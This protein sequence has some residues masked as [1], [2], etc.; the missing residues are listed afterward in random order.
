MKNAFE[1]VFQTIWCR[2][3]R[4]MTAKHGPL[5]STFSAVS[6]THVHRDSNSVASE[7]NPPILQN[8]GMV[9]AQGLATFSE[10]VLFGKSVAPL[11]HRREMRPS[12]S[13]HE[14]LGIAHLYTTELSVQRKWAWRMQTR[15]AFP[16]QRICKLSSAQHRFCGNAADEKVQD[17]VKKQTTRR[18]L[19]RPT[20]LRW[21][22]RG[23]NTNSG[24]FEYKNY[25]IIDDLQFIQESENDTPSSKN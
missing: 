6:R 4:Y 21:C 17:L 2:K 15:E 9:K 8:L 5:L 11:S 3:K 20:I 23:W 7:A 25:S 18:H 19:L 14:N 12:P 16:F 1:P 24:N 10:S 13:P 22:L